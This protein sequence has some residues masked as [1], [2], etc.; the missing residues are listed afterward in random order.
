[1]AAYQAKYNADP[2]LPSVNAYD[3]AKVI[4]AAV[5]AVKGDL[6]DKDKFLSALS[7]VQLNSP[8]GPI[9]FDERGQVI[10][11]LYICVADIK[12]GKMQN[13]VVDTIKGVRQRLP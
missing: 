5:T 2:A 7:K 3:A 1:V 4:L 13:N 8:R 11:N 6:S 9:Q 12:D 10:A